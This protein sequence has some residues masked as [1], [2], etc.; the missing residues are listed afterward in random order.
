MRYCE[1][2]SVN[3]NPPP[4]E[5]RRSWTMQQQTIESVVP[6]ETCGLPVVISVYVEQR[7]LKKEAR[8]VVFTAYHEDGIKVDHQPV[9]EVTG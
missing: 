6:C 3:G 9:V 7:P 1:L 5:F 8:P 2:P 4:V